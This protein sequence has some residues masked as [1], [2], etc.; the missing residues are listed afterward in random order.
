MATIDLHI[1][2]WQTKWIYHRISNNYV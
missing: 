1:G 2:C